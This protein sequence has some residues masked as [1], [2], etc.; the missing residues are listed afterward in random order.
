MTKKE[1]RSIIKTGYLY[2]ILKPKERPLFLD[3]LH[4]VKHDKNLLVPEN[5]SRARSLFLIGKY[6]LNA[7]LP[8]ME[9]VSLDENHAYIHV[10]EVIR[11]FLLHSNK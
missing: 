4:Y 2:N 10:D 1:S 3:M 7:N 9:V 5:E 11:Y 6:S 8:T